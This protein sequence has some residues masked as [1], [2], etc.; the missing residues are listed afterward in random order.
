MKVF[1]LCLMRRLN[2]E[3]M[4]YICE[5]I[6]GLVPIARAEA[7]AWRAIARWQIRDVLWRWTADGVDDNGLVTLEGI[8]Y[9]V[10]LYPATAEAMQIAEHG[11]G[12]LRHEHVVPRNWLTNRIIQENM[13]VEVIMELLQRC[14]LAAIV[15]EDQHGLLSGKMPVGWDWRNDNPYQRYINAELPLIGADGQELF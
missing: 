9:D 12:G 3:E 14:C 10:D 7:H 2:I 13:N 1:Y 5:F 15:T 8:K 11:G 6:G 4:R